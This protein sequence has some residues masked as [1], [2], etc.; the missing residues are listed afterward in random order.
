MFYLNQFFQIF[1]QHAVR[2]T[3]FLAVTGLLFFT[4]AHRKQIANSLGFGEKAQN[5][6]PYFHALISSKQNSSWVARKLR[7]LPG[8]EGV[9]VLPEKELSEQVRQLLAGM[10]HEVV[11]AV[12]DMQLAGLK[13]IARPELE[14]RSID[15][16]KDYLVRL[17]GKET[18]V[19]A[20]VIA[21]KA[22]KVATPLWH[23]YAVEI[24]LAF[25]GLIWSSIVM[26]LSRPLR[27]NAYL[28][29]QFQRRRGVAM[30]TWMTVVFFAVI[31][32]VG[33][34]FIWHPP[35]VL[36]LVMCSVVIFG[37]IFFQARRV[38]WEG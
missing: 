5:H 10:D 34:A 20:T 22:T 35:E 2:V 37:T 7:E 17:T 27:R 13:V 15:L 16:I 6:R 8:V 19:G 18:T 33:S 9:E 30:K 23:K 28:I 36:P 21:S 12:G 1:R 32:G 29:E 24:F 25:L 14:T 4:A 26:S 3:L 31:V 11:Q 38:S